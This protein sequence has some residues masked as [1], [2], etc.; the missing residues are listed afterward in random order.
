MFK[1]QKVSMAVRQV[2]FAS[3]LIATGPVWAQSTAATEA[4]GTEKTETQ[5]FLI[6]SIPFLITPPTHI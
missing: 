1:Q 5:A 4:A 3:T 2:L 6:I